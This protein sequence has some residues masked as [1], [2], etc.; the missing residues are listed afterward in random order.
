[1]PDST[2]L[3]SPNSAEECQSRP[4]LNGV[5][6]TS[7][8]V[9]HTSANALLLSRTEY[10]ITLQFPELP[11]VDVGGQKSNL[12]PPELCQILPNQPFRGKLTEEHTAAMITTAA[13]P[14]NI[15]A[16]YIA[17][18]GLDLLGFRKGAA[19]L[20]A[21]GVSIGSE[22]TVV[23]GRILPPPGIKYNASAPAVDE[24][25]S[26]NLRGVKFAKG[27]RLADW[28]VLLIK[29]GSRDEFSGPNDP[30]LLRTVK[31][32]ADMCGKSGME[33]DRKNPVIVVAVLPPKDYADPTRRA[34]INV[35]SG[36]LKSMKKPTIV[37]V[38]L[39]NGD[40]HIYSGL[41]H[42]CDSYLDLGELYICIFIPP[43]SRLRQATVCVHSSKIRKDK[44]V[45]SLH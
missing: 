43:C 21:F 30:E 19:P 3:R 7:Y 32:F 41:K 5:R 38:L 24:R 20:G 9:V 29:D 40:K 34:A 37:L 28:A 10:T 12:L 6:S 27:A 25:A 33:V 1:M 39:S 22:M 35:I 11:L 16:Q 31:G 36:T 23:P 2:H 14:P 26:W 45:L 44:G 4:I 13:R 8:I 17:N 15:N 18:Q 42:L